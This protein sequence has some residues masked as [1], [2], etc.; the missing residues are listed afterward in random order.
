MSLTAN[1]ILEPTELV[2]NSFGKF[3]Q[4]QRLCSCMA[5]LL[6]NG[7]SFLPADFYRVKAQ[8]GFARVIG[9]KA[10]FSTKGFPVPEEEFL[11]W[12]SRVHLLLRIYSNIDLAAA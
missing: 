4:R 1:G 5:T 11:P 6:P 2:Y 9:K 12:R 7:T 8:L 10:E 3:T